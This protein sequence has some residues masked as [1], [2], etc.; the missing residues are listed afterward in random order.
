LREEV[1]QLESEL[2]AMIIQ[3]A[4]LHIEMRQLLHIAR[5]FLDFFESFA[6]STDFATSLAVRDLLMANNLSYILDSERSRATSGRVLVFA[7]NKH[8]QRGDAEWQ[9]GEMANRWR[10]AGSYMAER[11]GGKYAVIGTAVGK[12][13]ENG[14]ATPEPGTL[15]AELLGRGSANRLVRAADLGGEAARPVRTGSVRNGTYFP[16]NAQSATDFDYIAML[17]SV[18]YNIGGRPL[19]PAPQ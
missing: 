11:L 10:P 3:D 8:L 16:L 14:I 13:D 17:E 2:Q 9:Y 15:E 4:P 6:R 18:T 12:S 7:H 19:P 1:V 5:E